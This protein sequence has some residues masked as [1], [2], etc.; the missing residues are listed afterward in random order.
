MTSK[1]KS[2]SQRLDEY[3]EL[4]EAQAELQ[5][6]ELDLAV[7]IRVCEKALE[8]ASLL[9]RTDAGDDRGVSESAEFIKEFGHELDPDDIEFLQQDYHGTKEVVDHTAIPAT[10]LKRMAVNGLIDF[11]KT[12]KG[13]YRYK[14]VSVMKYLINRVPE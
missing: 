4:L 7:K 9:A 3:R 10:S 11:T 13:H 14:S 5:K 1:P 2:V 6:Q 8:L 12:A